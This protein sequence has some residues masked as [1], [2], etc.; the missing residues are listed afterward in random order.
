MTP[1]SNLDRTGNLVK[2]GAV[3]SSHHLHFKVVKVR[4]GRC[5]A[6]Q[7]DPWGKPR[8]SYLYFDCRDLAVVRRPQFKPVSA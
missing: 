3:V 5:I 6:Q 8:G 1:R 4:T 2:R 7:L